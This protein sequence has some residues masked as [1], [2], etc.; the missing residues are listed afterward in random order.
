MFVRGLILNPAW[1]RTTVATLKRICVSVAS[2][3]RARLPVQVRRQTRLS[4]EVLQ[5]ICALVEIL[6]PTR[7]PVEDLRW[8]LVPVDQWPRV[9]AEDLQ[10]HPPRDQNL[11]LRPALRVN[12]ESAM[13]NRF[14]PAKLQLLYSQDLTP[15][16]V[17]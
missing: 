12:H 3:R 17:E 9:Q 2:R 8:T 11:G 5:R 14:P 13:L 16:R 15:I 4:V 7:V 1:N 6:R 10:T